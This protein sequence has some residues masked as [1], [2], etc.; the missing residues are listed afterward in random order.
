GFNLHDNRAYGIGWLFGLIMG[1]AGP[2]WQ[3]MGAEHRPEPDWG[4]PERLPRYTPERKGTMAAVSHVKKMWVDCTGICWFASSGLK[5]ADREYLPKVMA[6]AVGW[7]G[8]SFEEGA[9]VGERVANLQRLFNLYRG[10]K[11]Q[12]DFD[13][14]KRILEPIPS[15]PRKGWNLGPHFG[16]MREDY[17]AYLNWD[18]PTGAPRPEALAKVGLADRRIGR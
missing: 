5:G 4:Y 17:Y 6:Y 7:D 13:V 18:A 9:I 14:G 16:K 2:T 11:A 15:G 10:Y 1:G 3:A 12:D 8:F